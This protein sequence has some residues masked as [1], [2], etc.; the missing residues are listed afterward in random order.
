MDL[1]LSIGNGSPMQT[2]VEPPQLIWGAPSAAER[3]PVIATLRNPAHRNAVGSHAGGYSV[4]RALAIAARTLAHDH[5]VCPASSRR[6][7]PKRTSAA[8][9][10]GGD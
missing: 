10:A 4:Y 5:I 2:A 7:Q 3:G 8:A 9:D 6:R 1:S